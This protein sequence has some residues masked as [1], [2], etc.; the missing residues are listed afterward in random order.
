MIEPAPSP[1]E[2]CRRTQ[3]S[4]ISFHFL[5]SSFTSCR[6]SPEGCLRKPFTCRPMSVSW[7]AL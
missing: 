1:P 6:T 7:R 2:L 3:S 5:T 4:T